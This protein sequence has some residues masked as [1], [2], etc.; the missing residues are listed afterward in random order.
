MRQHTAD[1]RPR[2][3]HLSFDALPHC[4]ASQWN[5]PTRIAAPSI[6]FSSSSFACTPAAFF[7]AANRTVSRP[8]VEFAL[9]PCPIL[10][11]RMPD[12]RNCEARRPPWDCPFA[13][14]NGIF[15]SQRENHRLAGRPMPTDASSEIR[16]WAWPICRPQSELAAVSSHPFP[17]RSELRIFQNITISFSALRCLRCSKQFFDSDW[18]DAAC[19]MA[20]SSSFICGEIR[21]APR[22]RH[23][24]KTASMRLQ[25]N[26]L[27]RIC[28][29][30]HTKGENYTHAHNS[31]V[32]DAT[33]RMIYYCFTTDTHT[34]TAALMHW[35][36][37]SQRTLRSRQRIRK[38]KWVRVRRQP[39]SVASAP[40]YWCFVLCICVCLPGWSNTVPKT[41]K[42][43]Q[44]NDR[45]QYGVECQTST[46]CG[47]LLVA[48]TVLF[49][50]EISIDNSVYTLAALEAHRLHTIVS[51]VYTHKNFQF[52]STSHLVTQQDRQTHQKWL[53]NI[54]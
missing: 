36:H 8:P 43:K 32:I 2:R 7:E 11:K 26:G 12:A 23:L 49:L 4:P 48:Q 41:T 9:C 27:L 1:T 19:Q 22:S 30:S 6:R 29:E 25:G 42:S 46:A 15:R 20:S 38:A 5:R 16:W 3:E 40:V 13:A 53:Q 47:V 52:A 34:H 10:R 31:D 21:F 50:N 33:S 51:R 54:N 37:P 28:S 45:F 24:P 35:H 39:L 17:T 18:T 14:S 44:T